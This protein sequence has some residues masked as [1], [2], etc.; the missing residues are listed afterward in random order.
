MPGTAST[1]TALPSFSHNQHHKTD[2]TKRKGGRKYWQLNQSNEHASYYSRIKQRQIMRRYTKNTHRK[3]RINRQDRQK[4]TFPGSAYPK[5]ISQ[6]YTPATHT[7]A[8]HCQRVL[9]GVF[10][11]YLWPLKAPGS[12]LGGGSP[13]LLSAHWRQYPR[14]NTMRKPY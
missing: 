12:T 8:V 1:V 5:E 6:Q 10:H 9:L 13:N 7:E 11:P 2:V 4:I 14:S 3:P